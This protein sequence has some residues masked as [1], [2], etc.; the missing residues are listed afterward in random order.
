M[1]LDFY[2]E[3]EFWLAPVFMNKV[4]MNI[5]YELIKAQSGPISSDLNT[6]TCVEGKA[7]SPRSPLSL[8]ARRGLW[9]EGKRHLSVIPRAQSINEERPTED[10]SAELIVYYAQ[11]ALVARIG[12]YCRK[13]SQLIN[14]P[15]ETKRMQIN[16]FQWEGWGWRD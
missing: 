5:I 9:E 14:V 4:H 6:M 10:E 15:N 7:E 11:C 3:Y 16:S 2:S 8:L 1:L 13:S 12:R